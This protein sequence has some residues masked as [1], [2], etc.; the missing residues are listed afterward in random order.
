MPNHLHVIW[1]MLAMNKKEMPY[2]SFN[3]FTAHQFLA[4]LN[5]KNITTYKENDSE[6]NHR[7]WKKRC[8][9]N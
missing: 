2:A 9:G 1:E 5:T 3:K 6:R 7:F 8:L 4:K